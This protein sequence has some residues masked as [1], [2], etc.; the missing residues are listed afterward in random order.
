MFTAITSLVAPALATVT[1]I[2]T[3]PTALLVAKK[4]AQ[5]AQYT[6]SAWLVEAAA[7]VY[8]DSNARETA[9]RLHV[10]RDGKSFVASSPVSRIKENVKV[11]AKS[12]PRLVS[13]Y[14]VIASWPVHFG[15]RKQVEHQISRSVKLVNQAPGLEYFNGEMVDSGL[16]PKTV[17]RYL[18]NEARLSRSGRRVQRLDNWYNKDRRT[19]G[20]VYL[21]A[22]L[23][24]LR[25][26]ANHVQADSV[27]AIYD[28]LLTEF[29][30]GSL[31]ID[32]QNPVLAGARLYDKAAEHLKGF[33]LD[34]VRDTVL[35]P[36]LADEDL[37]MDDATWEKFVTGWNASR[38]SRD[39]TQTA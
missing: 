27:G 6:V 31:D 15:L 19:P 12:L 21:D 14:A 22:E 20:Q 23:T 7:Q 29:V 28:M 17:K 32:L 34:I 18:R 5:V 13:R 25:H 35:R 39:Y 10:E 16:A 24:K 26:R 36:W 8:T 9:E 2:V 1:R 33:E 4:S 3:T 30:N 11:S 38:I 37:T